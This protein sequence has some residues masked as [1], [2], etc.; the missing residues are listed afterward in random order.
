MVFLKMSKRYS[1]K[2]KLSKE[3]IKKVEKDLPKNLVQFKK[4]FASSNGVLPIDIFKILERM[5]FEV[6]YG[7]LGKY[8]GAMLVDE[9]VQSIDGFDTNKIIVVNSKLSYKKSVFTL[10]HELAHFLVQ[11]WMNPLERLQ[12]EFREHSKK[13]ERDDTENLMDYIA[14]SILMPEDVFKMSLAQKN[15]TKK[16][17]V[18]SADV[19]DALAQQYDVEFEAARRRIGE[20]F[21]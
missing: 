6:Y 8:D 18:V 11:R 14:A 20:V 9:S 13:G 3:E 15:I 17:D 16:E 1:D 4:D 12:I 2:M 21:Q 7:K 10:A 5:G 19:V